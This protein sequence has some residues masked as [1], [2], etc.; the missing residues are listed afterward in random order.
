MLLTYSALRQ[1]LYLVNRLIGAGLLD[2]KSH[3]CQLLMQMSCGGRMATKRIIVPKRML[4]YQRHS[5]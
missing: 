1:R 4:I 3:K 2:L 5:R